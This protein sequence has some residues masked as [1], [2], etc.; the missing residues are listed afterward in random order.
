MTIRKDTL[1]GTHPSLCLSSLWVFNLLDNR[2]SRVRP[3][4]KKLQSVSTTNLMLNQVI[5]TLLQLVF[6]FPF[7]LK[8]R[9]YPCLRRCAYSQVGIIQNHPSFKDFHFTSSFPFGFRTKPHFIVSLY[10]IMGEIFISQV[11]VN[12]GDR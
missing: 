4:R 6:S 3:D 11:F 7:S 5:N 8:L 2:R 10:I 12:C 1:I 9:I